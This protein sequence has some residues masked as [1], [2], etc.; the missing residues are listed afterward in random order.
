M[1]DE[2][3]LQKLLEVAFMNGWTPACSLQEDILDDYQSFEIGAECIVHNHYSYENYKEFSLND[4]VTNFQNN[5]QKREVSFIE[6]L[7]NASQQIDGD[8][9]FTPQTLRQM[10]VQ[11]PT[12]KR[13]NWLFATFFH[14]I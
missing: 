1:T 11:Q 12:N 3:K 13:L 14:L 9:G 6:A 8:I 2:Q 4:L 5:F 10:W 7:I